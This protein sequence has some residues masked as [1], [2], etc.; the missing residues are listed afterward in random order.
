MHVTSL[1]EI[2]A[3]APTLALPADAP[4]VFVIQIDGA[5]PPRVIPERDGTILKARLRAAFGLPAM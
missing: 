3:L 5:E 4:R 2:D 1:A